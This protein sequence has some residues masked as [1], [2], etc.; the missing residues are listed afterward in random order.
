MEAYLDQSAT[1]RCS[2]RVQEIVLKMM[3][4][5]YGNPS[6][7]HKKGMEAECFVKEAAQSIA[8]TLKVSEKEIIFTSGGTESNNLALMGTAMA[9]RR[10]GNRL[11]TTQIEHP[12]VLNTMK[13]LQ[14]QGFEVIYLPVNKD[15]II[16]QQALKEAVNDKTLL[17]SMMQINNEIG[18]VQPIAE[19][20]KIIHEKNPNTLLH[21]DA[22]QSYGKMQIRP[23]KLGIDL[24]SV[25][26]HKI[27]GPKGIGFL[28]RKDKTK[29][30]P[31]FF[32]GGQQS[33]LRSG[34]LN[35]P[36]I[37]GIGQAAALAY[38]DLEQKTAHLWELKNR[39]LAQ[40]AKIDGIV[41]NGASGPDS[42]PHIINL[43]VTGIRSE[44]ML[45]A[46]E[47]YGVYVSAGSAC[48]SHHHEQSHTLKA[49]GLEPALAQ[50]ALR[51]S[52]SST[53]RLQEIDYAAEKLAELA[54]KLRRYV[55]H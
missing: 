36:G 50:S 54:P 9:Y 10:T 42:A 40:T 12:S 7:M 32:G 44:V 4:I 39:L 16:L 25:S 18:S 28:Y 14:E 35:V 8:K 49:I 11:I 21:V 13:H 23:K 55:R 43:S 33:G 38:E 5:S 52:F 1:T 48:A 46:L 17:V 30:N 41:I 47:E 51:F 29:I 27:H 26:G 53:T 20:A 2:K 22:V 15:G 19:A 34:T 24:L 37:A 3:D 6:S 31:L 45:H